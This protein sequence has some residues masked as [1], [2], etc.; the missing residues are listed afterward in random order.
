MQKAALLYNPDSGGRRERRRIQLE[1]VLGLL[2][3]SKVKCELLLAHSAPEAQQLARGAIDEGCDTVFACG[4]DGTINN[5]IQVLAH[6]QVALAVL[7][8]GTANAL[9]HDLGL[10]MNPT[11]A[12]R[13]LLTSKPRRVALGRLHYRDLH[14]QSAERF[15]VVAAGAGVDAHL[16][17]SLHSGTKSRMGMAA[18]Y[19][20]AWHLWLAHP[21]RRFAIEFAESCGDARRNAEVTEL[22]AVRIRN[23]GGLLGELAPGAGL[24]RNDARL[25][26]CRTDSRFA[27]LRY[28]SR[29]FLRTNWKVP[30]I[31]LA[32]SARVRCTYT[33]DESAGP[34][35]KPPK[36]YVETDGELVG[37]LPADISIVPDALTLL[38][39]E[40]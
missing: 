36:V 27:Y 5:I 31:E 29:G 12:A 2:R 8:I 11:T 9:A 19:L 39:P 28:V 25:V 30:G 33:A 32:H 22:L 4:G 16:F 14:G 6:T 23:F 37:T 15:F 7:P 34:D 3:Q 38:A 10:P 26:F 17:Y 18:Y 20:K 13:R 1:S 21:M 40:M 24:E 35:G